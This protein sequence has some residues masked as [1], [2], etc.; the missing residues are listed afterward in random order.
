MS[1]FKQSLNDENGDALSLYMNSFLR[2]VPFQVEEKLLPKA[3][4]FSGQ[5]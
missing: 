2:R 4:L 5:L 1:K 3:F